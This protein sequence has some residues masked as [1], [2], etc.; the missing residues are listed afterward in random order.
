MIEVRNLIHTY[1]SCS[2]PVT[3]QY[4]SFTVHRGDQRVLMGS[5]GS[6]KTTLLHYLSGLL[7]AAPGQVKISGTDLAGLNEAQRD[8]FRA[9]HLGYI[10]QDFHLMQGYTALENVMLALGLAGV[11]PRE[12]K[13]RATE[14][15][16]RVDLGHRLHHL[17]VQLSTGERQRVAI[18][19]AIVNRPEV[20]LAD[21]PTAHLDEARSHQVM[22][23]LKST[24]QDLNA[25][26]IVVTHDPLVKKHIPDLL[27]LGALA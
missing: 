3:L 21:E 4:P 13:Q 26:L 27:T 7:V 23:L 18:A 11:S 9:R 5:S 12:R 17:P 22:D 19:R 10:F 16:S 24:A 14:A 2:D 1:P 15:L 6:G 8:G 20:L 25:A